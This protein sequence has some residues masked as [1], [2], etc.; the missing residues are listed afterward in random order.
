MTNKI[1]ISKQNFASEVLDGV[2]LIKSAVPAMIEFPARLRKR[3]S[4]VLYLAACA[5]ASIFTVFAC[6]RALGRAPWIDEVMLFDNY[7]LSNIVA[8]FRPLQLYDQTATPLYSLLYGWTASLPVEVIRAIHASTLLFCSI[9]IIGWKRRSYL[10]IAASLIAVMAFPS[11]VHYLYEMKHYGLEAIG[12]LG[13]FSW[14]INK[15][16]SAKYGFLDCIFLLL[17]A[18]L[19]IST[20]PVAGMAL[21]LYMARRAWASRSIKISEACWASA[22][23]SFLIGYYSLIKNI[24]IF[25]LNNYPGPYQYSGFASSIKLFIK[26]LVGLLPFG[27]IGA[28]GLLALFLYL[29][30]ER[31]KRQQLANLLVISIS[32]AVIFAFLAGVDLYPVKYT[33]HV[34]W[35]SSLAW[36][37]VYESFMLFSERKIHSLIGTPLPATMPELLGQVHS[38]VDQRIIAIVLT[39]AYALFIF[40]SSINVARLALG[41]PS[42]DTYQAIAYVRQNPIEEVALFGGAQAVKGFYSKRYSSLASKSFFGEM[43]SQSVIALPPNSLNLESLEININKP[44]AYAR[45]WQRNADQDGAL[46]EILSKAPKNKDFLLFSYWSGELSDETRKV[47]MENKCQ[48]NELKE[49]G[50]AYVSK[51]LCTS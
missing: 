10:A 44:G 27:R 13:I 20:L 15:D 26:A 36:L 2:T 3:I 1:G 21:A 22:S 11:G 40:S 7:P 46:S 30:L 33:R 50:R 14:Y 5:I 47:I 38:A 49:F 18:S 48:I 42:K 17:M 37:I 43:K 16:V 32:I 31:G 29:A 23:F 39:S 45:F 35:A 8:G 25:Q 28:A 24:A 4:P 51:I 19:G 41:S 9:A 6:I 34:I 12:A